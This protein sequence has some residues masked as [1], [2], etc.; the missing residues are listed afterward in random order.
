ML[1]IPEKPLTGGYEAKSTLSVSEAA[2][3]G[4]SSLI[5]FAVHLIPGSFHPFASSIIETVSTLSLP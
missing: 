5:L 2:L 1:E 4:L 3:A